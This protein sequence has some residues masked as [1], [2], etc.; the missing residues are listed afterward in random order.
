M[1]EVVYADLAFLADG[2]AAGN[3]IADGVLVWM[4]GAVH[5]DHIDGAMGI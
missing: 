3:A 5:G 1:D 4:D 2:P